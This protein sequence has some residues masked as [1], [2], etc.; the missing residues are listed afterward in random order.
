[1]LGRDSPE[2]VTAAVLAKHLAAGNATRGAASAVQVLASA[3]ALDGHPVARAYRDAK[4]MEIIEG[5]NEI[6]QLLLS[7]HALEVWA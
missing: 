4:L 1:M 3:G 6:S 2:L 7:K 5:S